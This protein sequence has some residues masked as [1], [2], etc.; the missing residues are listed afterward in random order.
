MEIGFTPSLLSWP[1]WDDKEEDELPSYGGKVGGSASA[2]TDF[3][4]IESKVEGH[5]EYKDDH[6][7]KASI[8]VSGKASR[9]RDGKTSKEVSVEAKYEREF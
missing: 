9:D 3:D 7:N 8:E 2:K 1:Q 5:G 4:K 6:G